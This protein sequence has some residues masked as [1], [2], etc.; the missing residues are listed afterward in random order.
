MRPLIRTAAA[1]TAVA[2]FTVATSLAPAQPPIP[3]SQL[4]SPLTSP[5][6]VQA[7][8]R[9]AASAVHPGGHTAVAVVLDIPDPLHINSNQPADPTLIPTQVQITNPSPQITVHP[10]QYPPTTSLTLIPSDP[11]TSINVYAGQAVVYLPISTSQTIHPGSYPLTVTVSWQACENEICYAPSQT[12]L[13][14]DLIVAHPDT[15]VQDLADPI[16]AGFDPAAFSTTAAPPPNTDQTTATP[17]AFFGWQFTISNH[18]SLTTALILLIA[19]TAGILLNF[20]PCVLPV[21]PIKILS[22]QQQATNPSRLLALAAS[23]SAGIVACFSVLGILAAGMISGLDRLQ[24][25]QQFSA[26]WFTIALGLI[27]AAMGLGTLGLFSARLPRFVYQFSPK[28]DT[29]WGSFS[30]GTLTA[31]LSTPCTGPLFAGTFA[32]ALKQ[33]P[34]LALL[35]F[36]T[37]GL[38]MALPYILLAANPRWIDRL[39][40]T[41][42]ASHLAKQVIGLLMLAVAVYFFGIAGS[43]RWGQAYW[44]PVAAA[45]T[46]AMVWL[47]YNATHTAKRKTAVFATLALA[48]LITASA[49]WSAKTLT[50]PSPIPWVAYDDTA[51]QKARQD[52]KIVVLEFTADWCVN[53]KFLELSVL[54]DPTVIQRFTQ[55]D[56]IPMRVDLTSQSNT[57]G[58]TKLKN[59]GAM[60][61]PLTAVLHPHRDNPVVLTSLYTTTALL[62]A[63][64]QPN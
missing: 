51:L 54:H 62:N 9:W 41:G 36:Q 10:T 38:G 3:T 27:V 64:D 43:T 2:I 31:V 5:P 1:L 44:W 21:V 59:L 50:S 32:W 60:G 24:W 7:H 48:L 45:V 34:W 47:A 33:P 52:G 35:T 28:H 30:F 29:H 12:Q 22:L 13:N 16:F 53:C 26:T 15:P 56:I 6:S 63:I 25:G 19:L 39:P 46:V 14:P 37:M 40:R 20:M 58:W 42:P 23:F 18:Q 49:W 55:S 11:S 4:P 57:A 8:A 61:I 17:F